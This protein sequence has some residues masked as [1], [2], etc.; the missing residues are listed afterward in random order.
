MLSI[1]D[2]GRRSEDPGWSPLKVGCLE[3]RG[4]KFLAGPNFEVYSALATGLSLADCVTAVAVQSA[5]DRD[6]Q[7]CVTEAVNSL[8]LCFEFS[9]ER[10]Y[11]P[12]NDWF[13]DP[14]VC[15]EGF[16]EVIVVNGQEE[17]FAEEGM[18]WWGD[19]SRLGKLCS[20]PSESSFAAAV[21][22]MGEFAGSE[23]ARRI[24]A[25]LAPDCRLR[26]GRQAASL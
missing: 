5:V 24:L 12:K 2:H 18:I 15:I 20:Q 9:L 14:G 22:A 8:A 11:L 25:E 19:F 10:L 4:H 13:P 7:A 26:Q 6:L 21:S 23:D 1:S 17:V 3:K 16:R